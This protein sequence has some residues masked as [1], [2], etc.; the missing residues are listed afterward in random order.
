MSTSARELQA[1]LHV[2][3]QWSVRIRMQINTHNTKVMAF[4]ETL[5]LQKARGG[6]QQS[7][8]T[9]YP[10]QIHAP[11]PTSDPRSYLKIEV[12]HFEYLGLILDPKLTMHLAT[13]KAIRRATHGQSVTKAFSF[14]FH[15]EKKIPPNAKP[16]TLEI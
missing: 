16:G 2:C 8:P 12:L 5:S 15:Y 10:F 7:S 6:Q 4:F 13:P 1:M 3:Q 14:S 9:H 11:F